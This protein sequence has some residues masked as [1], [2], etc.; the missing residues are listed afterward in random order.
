MP[1]SEMLS[2]AQ[3]ETN[4]QNIHIAGGLSKDFGLNGF[5]V[6]ILHTKNQ[7]LIKGMSGIS[8]FEGVSNVT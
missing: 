5:R 4:Y 8:Y 3:M 6:G 2:I 1:G 7:N